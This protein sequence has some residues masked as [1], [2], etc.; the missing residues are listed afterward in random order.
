MT[1]ASACLKWE[2]LGKI[3]SH[4]SQVNIVDLKIF[5]KIIMC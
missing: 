3:P 2:M 4:T 1:S 5:L